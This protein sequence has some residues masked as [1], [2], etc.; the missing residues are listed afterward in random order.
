M[1]YFRKTNE[2]FEEFF[3]QLIDYRFVYLFMT[4]QKFFVPKKNFFSNLAQ[5]YTNSNIPFLNYI[6]NKLFDIM[7][8]SKSATL[9]KSFKIDLCYLN[10]E[11]NLEIISVSFE[12]FDE[13]FEFLNRILNEGILNKFNDIVEVPSNEEYKLF[14]NKNRCKRT[15]DY[16]S[17]NGLNFTIR[18]TFHGKDYD[19]L[20]PKIEGKNGLLFKSFYEQFLNK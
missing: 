9:G 18:F 4:S 16:I 17:Q 11:Y 2:E 7:L 14:Y 10:D 3:Q 5:K 20:N 1:E 6:A 13:C 8:N 19:Y 12:T 15:D